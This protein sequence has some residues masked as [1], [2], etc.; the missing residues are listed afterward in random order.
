MIDT[1]TA[2]AVAAIALLPGGLY[3]WAYEEEVGSSRQAFADRLLRFVAVSAL[4]HVVAAPLTWWFYQEEI[5]SGRFPHE[6]AVPWL[7][8]LGLFGYVLVPAALGRIV[9]II[10]WRRP[11][12]LRGIVGPAPAARAWDHVFSGGRAAWIRVR[13][14]DTDGGTNGWI[15]GA[16]SR[17]D[18]GPAGYAAGYPHE[19]DLYLADT[20]EVDDRGR[21]LRDPDGT[22]RRR[23]WGALLNWA[24]ISYLEVYWTEEA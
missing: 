9:G 3:T 4:L 8:W 16:Y 7:V 6:P 14:K 22:V 19:Q 18:H 17:A 11:R 24:E 13:L 23:G 5:R 15:V 10:A 2:L 1:F 20:A 21:V 12:W